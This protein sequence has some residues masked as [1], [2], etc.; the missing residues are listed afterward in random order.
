MSRFLLLFVSF[1]LTIDSFD[2][3]RIIGLFLENQN[4]ASGHFRSSSSSNWVTQCKAMFR[5]AIVLADRYKIYVQDQPINYT[6]LQTTF[7][8]NGFA[9]LEL[10]CQSITEKMEPDVVGIVGPTTST[11]ARFLGPFAAHVELPLISYA[12]TNAELEDTFT[13]QTFS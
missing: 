6:I 2:T 11:N 12:A 7:D 5:A 3:V 4:A 10:L 13:Y 9:A 8:G 1:V